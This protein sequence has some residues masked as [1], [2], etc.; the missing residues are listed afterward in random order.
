[1]FTEEQ[2][3]ATFKRASVE[4][5]GLGT[6]WMRELTE[7]EF[8]QW[9]KLAN[10]EGGTLEARRFM[11]VRCLCDEHG[12]RLY[13]NPDDCPSF[14]WRVMT[15]LGHLAIEVN[16]LTGTDK[17]GDDGSVSEHEKRVGNSEAETTR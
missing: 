1:M 17:S 11:V 6:V 12:N 13:E 9:N 7:D 8:L 16:G 4:V 10:Q 3:A 2:V 15:T 14:P 5:E